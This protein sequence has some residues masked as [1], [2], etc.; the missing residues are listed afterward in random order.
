MPTL[1]LLPMSFLI[2]APFLFTVKKSLDEIAPVHRRMSP[3]SVWWNLLPIF[4]LVWLFVTAVKFAESVDREARARRVQID[5]YPRAWGFA[6]ASLF[7]GFTLSSPM[8]DATIIM[9]GLWIF[10]LAMYWKCV[11]KLMVGFS[12]NQ[13]PTLP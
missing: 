2:L 11:A 13:F 9:F 3:S 10:T 5:E 8:P 4:N 6:F 12:G 7:I 1:V